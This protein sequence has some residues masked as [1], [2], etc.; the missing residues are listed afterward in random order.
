MTHDHETD[1]VRPVATP[2]T[3]PSGRNR[4]SAAVDVLLGQMKGNQSVIPPDMTRPAPQ[5]TSLTREPQPL[6]IPWLV[7]QRYD[8]SSLRALRAAVRRRLSYDASLRHW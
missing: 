4:M 7:R 5:P 3:T 6:G 1:N 8:V 2:H